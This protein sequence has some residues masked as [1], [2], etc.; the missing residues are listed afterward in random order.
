[1]KTIALLLII[2][3][4]TWSFSQP[5]DNIDILIQSEQN[6]D[7]YL[8]GKTIKIDAVVNGDLV[9]AGQQLIISDS[10]Y[11]D[12]TAAGANL[13]INKFI[14]DDVRIAAGKIIIDTEIGDDLVVFGGEVIISENAI[15]KGNLI[16]FAKDIEL[17][18]KIIGNL[19][20][21]GSKAIIN[22]EINGTSRIISEDIIIGPK[23]KFHKDVEYWNSAK[24]VDFKESLV[25]SKAHFNKELKKEKSELSLR[26][27]GMTSFS[28]WVF[29]ILSSLLVI[30]VLHG[31]FRNA[32]SNAV[33]GLEKNYL[34]SFGYGLIYLVG[35]PLVIAIAF[36]MVIG[37]PLGLFM[38]GIFLFSLLFG[39]LIAALIIAYYIKH[40]QELNWNFWGITFLALL[41]TIVLRLLTNIPFIGI[42]ISI[43]ILSITYG[44]L[45]LKVLPTKKA[46][47]QSL[48]S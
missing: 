9:A 2:F 37:I 3:C 4:A 32:F 5:E 26:T 12:L 33:E 24:Q 13:T 28:S 18:G 34:K 47:S 20:T 7:T 25:N 6:D 38:T 1:M 15:I 31:L 16:C 22:G 36:L 29:Y 21:K 39:H 45:T 44:A 27:F 42:V 43:V 46:P 48:V 19:E 17:N 11:G 40:K 35:V 23:A 14:G 30:L 41:F 10:I 8:A